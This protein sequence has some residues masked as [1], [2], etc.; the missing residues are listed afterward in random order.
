MQ[1]PKMPF[2][3]RARFEMSDE[4]QRIL[5]LVDGMEDDL[6]AQC[7]DRTNDIDNIRYA[8]GG[9]D[10]IKWFYEI[11]DLMYEDKDGSDNTK[12]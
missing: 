1:R 8:Q 7:V 10:V 5:E 11:L 3:D 2:S 4:W 9:I 6:I 12:R